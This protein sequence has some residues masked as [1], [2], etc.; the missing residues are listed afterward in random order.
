MRDPVVLELP[1]AGR[2][3]VQNSP[4]RRVPSHG[5]DVLGQRYAIDFVA[6]DERGRTARIRDRATVFGTEPPE[7]FA[8]FGLPILA[9]VS[10]RVVRVHDGEPDHAARRSPLALTA[11]AL[12][13]AG[14]L[15]AGPD[16][17]AGNHVLVRDA[18]SGALVALAHLRRGSLLVGVGDEVE[19]GRP[20]ASCGN[21]GNSTQPHLHLQAMDDADLA[22]GAGLPILF[23]RFRELRRRHGRPVDRET[24]LPDERSVVEP[25][26]PARSSP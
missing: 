4:A 19:A 12:G 24:G 18:A 5:V 23:R 6:V 26:P 21:S 20:V 10:G 7:R 8:A 2:W 14:R 11:Y 9:P 22:V 15:R 1:F 17:V 16:A 3:L 25:L 13:Q